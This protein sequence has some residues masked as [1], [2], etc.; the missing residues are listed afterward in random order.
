MQVALFVLFG[1]LL[2]IIFSGSYMFIVACRRGKEID[3]LSKEVLDR[4]PYADHYD[5]IVAA[6]KWIREQGAEDIYIQSHDGLR[7][8][9]KWIPAENPKGTVLL[10]H[11][12]RSCYLLDFSLVLKVY[13]NFGFNLLIPDQ[14][15]HRSS[16]GKYITFGVKESKDMLG[17]LAFHNEHY[18]NVPVLLSGMSM[19]ASTVLYMADEDLPDNV[20]G[21]IADCGFTSPKE[22]LKHVFRKT[23]H[24]PAGPIIWV[25]DLLARIFA[26][27]SL[28]AK[29]TRQTL[30]KSRVPVLMVH[31]M[32]DKFVPCDMTRQGYDACTS[33]KQLLLVAGAGHGVSY[34]HDQ[35]GYSAAVLYFLKTHVKNLD[36]E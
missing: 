5:N 20:C 24:F 25:A 18:G 2:L 7:L 35:V 22:I 17:W 12:Y 13:H 21:I 6:D 28:Y 30:A 19:G 1:I 32:E 23:V 27:F 36:F 15:S 10:A 8:H 14:R 11:G 16:E 34:F 26:G 33:E 29:D 9:A 3:W 31:G 4:T